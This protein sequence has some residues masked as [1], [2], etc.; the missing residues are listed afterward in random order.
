M[1]KCFI[2]LHQNYKVLFIKSQ[3]LSVF[4]GATVRLVCEH[5][6][7]FF[8]LE[9]PFPFAVICCNEFVVGFFFFFFLFSNDIL[10]KSNSIYRKMV[11]MLSQLL[12]PVTYL[13]HV[14]PLYR[15]HNNERKTFGPYLV[16]TFITIYRYT[17]K[18]NLNSFLSNI[19]KV[20]IFRSKS[21]RARYILFFH[22]IF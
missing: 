14:E 20:N 1:F 2:K 6:N 22:L 16:E 21:A 15:Y 19:S 8:S 12:E 5:E 10:G 18:Y 9:I 3:Y 13:E 7:I 4:S 17:H 11:T